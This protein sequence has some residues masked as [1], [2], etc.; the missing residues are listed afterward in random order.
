MALDSPVHLPPIHF[1]HGPVFLACSYIIIQVCRSPNTKVHHLP[2]PVTKSSQSP[3]KSF[4]KSKTI[5]FKF[6]LTQVHSYQGF[7][8][9]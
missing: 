6:L 5:E 1:S 7:E 2:D 4:P 8:Q 3:K 9:N